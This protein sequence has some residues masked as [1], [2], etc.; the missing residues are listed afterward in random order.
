LTLSAAGAG[1]VAYRAWTMARE[2][3]RGYDEEEIFFTVER[4]ATGL[5]I[6]ESLEERGIIR[7]RRLF[8]LA[9]RFRADGKSVQAGEYRFVEP[10]ST[11]D[12][13]SK[14]VSGD[15]F[16]FAVT[17]PE[18]LT[19]LETAELLAAQ[20]LA[21]KSALRAAFE[22]KTLVADLDPEARNLEGYL[23][24]TTYRFPRS[25]APEELARTLAGQFK[26]IF[27]ETERARAAKLGLTPRQV[28]TL[29]SVI[30]KETGLAEERPRIASVF[31]NR[32]RIGMP[33]QSDPTI[34]YALELA[35]RFDG[36]LKRTDLELDSPYNTYRYPGLPPGPIASPGEAS[37][38]AVLEPKE[39]SFLYFVSRNDG[40]HHFSST[41]SEH[42]NAV[43]R[44]QVEYFRRSRRQ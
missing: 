37:I 30:E 1:I 29:A 35:G 12:V 24:P 2:P 40:S 8:V 20:G 38:R 23:Y 36:N 26:R 7:D 32:L 25:V 13:L 16:T 18:G 3:F 17:I 6:A 21:E 31:S 4:G 34:I 44:Y 39:T 41:Y 22:E 19:L 15:T 27:D 43:R 14:L 28:V 42:V 33:L 9:L 11:F 10:L 5:R